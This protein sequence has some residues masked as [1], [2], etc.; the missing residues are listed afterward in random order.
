MKSWPNTGKQN[1]GEAH[2][3]ERITHLEAE[4]D[5]LIAKNAVLRGSVVDLEAELEKA[6]A[7]SKRLNG[8]LDRL[9]ARINEALSA[10]PKRRSGELSEF[11]EGAQYAYRK[12]LDKLE[13]PDHE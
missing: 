6:K 5:E 2:R 13:E 11:E 1:R 3:E 10:P 7:D 8:Y 12:V 4:R 9:K